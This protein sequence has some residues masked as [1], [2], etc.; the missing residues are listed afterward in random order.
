MQAGR[1]RADLEHPFKQFRGRSVVAPGQQHPALPG[2][3]S[4][5]IRRQ[6]QGALEIRSGRLRPTLIQPGLAAADEGDRI[7]RVALDRLV[8]MR[9][10]LIEFAAI[11]R[12]HTEQVMPIGDRRIQL[13]RVA[14]GLLGLGRKAV[15]K[16]DVTEPAVGIGTHFRR[17]FGRRRDRGSGRIDGLQHR[18]R[19]IASVHGVDLAQFGPQR[20][21]KQHREQQQDDP[22]RFH[23][24]TAGSLRPLPRRSE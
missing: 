12:Q 14:V 19:R 2:Q 1:F 13:T 21:R 20:L 5:R 17:R 6:G 7:E 9:Y 10:R 8:K 16:Q 11:D 15:R 18:L 22:R 23:G 4:G 3:C 24:P